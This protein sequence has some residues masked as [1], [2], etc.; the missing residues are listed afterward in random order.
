MYLCITGFLPNNA[1]DD[2]LKYELD[3]NAA[4]NDQ[5]VQLLGHESLETMAEGL[6]PLT[7]EQVAQISELIGQVLP[8]DLEML[9]GVEE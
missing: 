3:V 4:F 8:S 2:S 6:W 9:I 5:I 7:N 1:E